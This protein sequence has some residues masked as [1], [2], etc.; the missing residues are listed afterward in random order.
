MDDS[1]D[2]RDDL[3]LPEGDMGK[4]I[5]K[6]ITADESFFVSFVLSPTPTFCMSFW[7]EMTQN[8]GRWHCLMLREHEPK[9]EEL[10]FFFFLSRGHRVEG[11]GWGDS[12]RREGAGHLSWAPLFAATLPASHRTFRRRASLLR[13]LKWSRIGAGSVFFFFFK[14]RYLRSSDWQSMRLA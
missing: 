9:Y 6:R 12:R 5:E 4:E 8:A 14:P 11:N 10:L 13:R 3:K 7:K 2:T 1:A